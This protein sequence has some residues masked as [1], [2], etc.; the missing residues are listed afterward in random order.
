[1]YIILL[2]WSPLWPLQGECRLPPYSQIPC[3]D[4]RNG[5]SAWLLLSH[6]R[7]SLQVVL[8]KKSGS[9]HVADLHAL[10][11]LEADFNASMKILVGHWMVQQALQ[12]ILIPPE[13][14]GSVPGHHTIQ[15]SFNFCLLDISHQ[16]HQEALSVPTSLEGRTTPTNYGRHLSNSQQISI[17]LCILS[18]EGMVPVP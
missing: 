10:G 1:M 3:P 8:E 13:C 14:Y 17:V 12:A 16:C 15:V 9:I 2:L 18:T 11:L 4:H 5:L 6:W 7:S